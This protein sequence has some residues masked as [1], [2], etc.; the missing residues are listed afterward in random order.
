MNRL[1][2]KIQKQITNK[3]LIWFIS[4]KLDKNMHIMPKIHGTPADPFIHNDPQ[5]PLKGETSSKL[6]KLSLNYMVIHY[7]CLIK[8]FNTCIYC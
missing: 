6:T 8:R 7:Y 4:E 1:E 5:K 2:K 3:C